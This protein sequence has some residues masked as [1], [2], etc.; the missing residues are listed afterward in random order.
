[1]KTSRL[2]IALQLTLRAKERFVLRIVL[3]VDQGHSPSPSSGS[4]SFFKG[5]LDWL[6]ISLLNY[7]HIQ[8]AHPGVLAPS[9]I[10]SDDQC[11]VPSVLFSAADQGFPPT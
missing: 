10:R 9:H 5:T 3:D 7:I 1:M 4:P 2:V 6:D 8:A 11:K